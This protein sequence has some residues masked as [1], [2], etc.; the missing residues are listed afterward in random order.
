MLPENQQQLCDADADQLTSLTREQLKELE[1]KE[2]TA[3]E[4]ILE[5]ITIAMPVIC[6]LIAILEYTQIPDKSKNVHPE[7]YFYLLCLSIAAYV[8]YFIIAL[9]RKRAGV[10]ATYER[11]H[12]KAPLFAGLFVFLAFY[13][14]MT[15]KTGI[16]TQPFVP[17][18]NSIINAFCKDYMMLL[19][20]TLNTLKL[21]LLG[22]S[23]GVFLGLITG[24]TCGYSKKVRYWIDPIIK[25]L[26]PIPTS[27]WIPVTMVIASSLFGGAVFIIALGAWFAVT[28][29]SMTGISNVDKDFFEAARTLGA[30]ER[31][32]VF[33][34]AIPHAMPSILQG[35]TQGMSSS[36]VALII[37]EMLGV[38]SGL[39]WYMTWQTGWAS[40]DKTFAA[41]F[42][43]C[44]IFTMVTKG[45]EK[46]K[47]HVLRWQNGAEK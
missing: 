7:R 13:D 28:V 4:K 47:R 33:R 30:S 42:V 39:G 25:F 37:A 3:K 17:C 36:C 44:F 23:A 45:L 32:L 27:T 19:D 16:L 18:M 31:Q 26:G 43:I 35:C 20:C 6:G 46:I 10:N 9:V 15:L 38:K 14:Y 8:V 29:A 21:L 40:Y 5:G 1:T 24:I 41:L 34:V 2:K 11:V 12:Y 22:Y